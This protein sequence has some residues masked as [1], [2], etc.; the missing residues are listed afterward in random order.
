M[1]VCLPQTSFRSKLWKELPY[2]VTG[3]VIVVVTGEVTVVKIV[4]ML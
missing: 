1:S 4:A 3:V 2:L